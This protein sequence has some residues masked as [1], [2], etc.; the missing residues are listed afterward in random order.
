M[1]IAVCVVGQLLRL[2]TASKIALKA[3]IPEIDFF[4]VLQ[5][6]RFY[7]RSFDNCTKV[8]RQASEVETMSPTSTRFVKEDTLFNDTFLEKVLSRRYKTRSLFFMH[9]RQYSNW[10]QCAIDIESHEVNTRNIYDYVV[11]LRDNT[12]VSDPGLMIKTLNPR[13]CSTKQ[14]FR[15]GGIHDKVMSCPRKY[16]QPMM[17]DI[18]EN[19]LLGPM[20]YSRDKNTE[21]MLAR[22]LKDANVRTRWLRWYPAHDVRPCKCNSTHVTLWCSNLTHNSRSQRKGK[23]CYPMPFA[24]I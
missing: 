21:T 5:T 6:S 14:C 9:L 3:H 13:W 10:R 17:R 2:E 20:E 16:L 22:T 11:R 18:S 7:S 15:W 24:K 23:D 12:F 8:M 4:L 19:M 1:R